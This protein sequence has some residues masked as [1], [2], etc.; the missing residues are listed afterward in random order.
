MVG[1]VSMSCY[2][3]AVTILP[4]AE[5][6]T[7][8]FS[9]AIWAVILSS[10]LLKEKVGIYRW[11]AVIL[12]FAGVLIITQPGS[13]HLPLLGAGLALSAAFLISLI[14]I[15]I[16][17]LGRTEEPLTVV[18]YFSLF[19]I[20]VLGLILPFVSTPLDGYQWG[21]MMALASLGLISQFLLTAALRFGVVASVMVMDYSSLIWAILLGW[22][23]FGNLPPASTWIGAPLV[24]AA[25][26]VVAW[27]EHKLAKKPGPTALSPGGPTN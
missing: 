14:S 13:G 22:S 4:L 10:V 16:R 5:A 21:L 12:G 26:L 27:R 11:S 18:F 15:Q 25:G 3:G 24:V 20:P 1:L 17:D 7:I 19:S 8:T 23:L 2:F 6:T 9:S